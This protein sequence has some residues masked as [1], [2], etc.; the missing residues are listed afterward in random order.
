[1]THL[2][3]D[4]DGNGRLSKK[5]YSAP[6]WSAPFELG[7]MGFQYDAQGRI[8]ILTYPV[9]AIDR[10]TRWGSP[11]Q[12]QYA[13]DQY[14]GAPSSLTDLSAPNA[15]IWSVTAR[16][17]RGQPK[18]EALAFAGSLL[19]RSTSYY[20][21][22]GHANT[23]SLGGPSGAA[24][25]TYSYDGGGLPTQ[26]VTAGAAG[27]NWQS[28]FGYDQ[29]R[30]L[31]TW[32]TGLVG[33]ATSTVAYSYDGDGNMTQRSWTGETVNYTSQPANNLLT[34]AVT[35]GGTSV[36]NDNYTSDVWGRTLQT[37]SVELTYNELDEIVAAKELATGQ[38]DFVKHDGL[39]GRLVTGY[40]TAA[41]GQVLH[42]LDDLYTFKTG[43]GGSE[44]RCRLKVNDTLIGELVRT[45]NVPTRSATFYLTDNVGS[46]A[47]ESSP[48]SGTVTMRTRRDPFG[49]LSPTSQGP[50]LAPEATAASQDGSGRLGFGDHDRDPAWSLVD[51]K[52]RAYNPQLGRFLSPDPI[53]TNPF[54]RN[55]HNAF[56]Y[57]R[58]LPTVLTDPDGL[59]DCSKQAD[60]SQPCSDG[61]V[62][63]SWKDLKS[64][65]KRAVGGLKKGAEVTKDFFVDG[66]NYLSGGDGSSPPKPAQVSTPGAQVA[67]TS[68]NA[69]NSANSRLRA[70]NQV[71]KRTMDPTLLTMGGGN[72]VDT[73]G[74]YPLILGG[75]AAGGAGIVLGPVAVEAVELFAVA[76]PGLVATGTAIAAGE[77]GVV[78]TGGNAPRIVQSMCFAEGTKV[79]MADGSTKAIEDVREGDFVL[80]RDPHEPGEPEP[81]KV[82]QVHHTATYRLFHVWVG[83]EDGG[84]VIATGSHPFWTQRGWVEAEDLT[85]NDVLTDDLR[86]AIPIHAIAVESR[87]ART[88]NLSIEGTHTF[89]VLAGRTP[90]LVHNVD[91]W[92]ILFSQD[93]FGRTFSD[94][95]SPWAGKSLEEAAAATRA[96]GRLPP[97]L[98][99][100]VM[101]VNGQWVALNNRTLEVARMAN[102]GQVAINDVGPSGLN[103]LMKNLSGSG[104]VAP[105]RNAVM[106]CR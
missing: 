58:N 61:W 23:R 68:P 69:T 70:I 36:R 16:D 96:L 91:P 67:R 59:A 18:T 53:L 40:G 87:D 38:V 79:L 33:Q 31:T 2:H 37:P 32:Q 78:A 55:A 104:L 4:Y 8:S 100:D 26:I 50:Y 5:T 85:S 30:R 74:A 51:M 72:F 10:N 7:W 1:M 9:A 65:G 83:D 28:I 57:V 48:S 60:T 106:R 92:D 42:T 93:S 43:S 101:L 66:Y 41:S 15:P 27:G 82:S 25:L 84:E 46:V 76:H 77:G 103:R 6:T 34:V 29:L 75:A 63:P 98:T 14:N 86:R 3:F 95:R 21:P 49:N 52:A 64:A 13:Y 39:G 88:F 71:E 17:E 20:L 90:V 35:R 73:S 56:A 62:L 102:L 94:A 11:L 54:D 19:T 97:G 99:L 89:F 12:V 24:S 22:T 45:A 80:A 44:E 47:A 81:R 105:V